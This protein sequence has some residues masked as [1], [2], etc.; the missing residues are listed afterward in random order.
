VVFSFKI[1]FETTNFYS[2]NLKKINNFILEVTRL[3]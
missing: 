2:F 3:Y 1:F